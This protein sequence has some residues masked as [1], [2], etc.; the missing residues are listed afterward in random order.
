MEISTNHSELELNLMN[1]RNDLQ[2]RAEITKD[3]SWDGGGFIL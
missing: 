1:T 3:S 2:V